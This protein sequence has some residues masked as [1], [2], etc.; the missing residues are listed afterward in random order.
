MPPAARTGTRRRAGA[1]PGRQ[2]AKQ[3]RE[4]PL[5]I[6]ETI[7]DI[8]VTSLAT[9]KFTKN[10]LIHGPSGGGK[11]LL[12]G[13]VTRDYKAVFLSTE[14]E[15]VVSAR[16]AG[17]TAGLMRAPSWEAAVSGVAKAEDTLGPD[18]FLIVDSGTKM[19]VLYMRW[20]L[21]TIHANN[22]QRDLDIPAIQD[23][24][25]YQNGFMRWYDRIIDGPFNSIFITTSMTVEDAE[26]ETRVIPHI[27]GKKGEISDYISA[28]ASVGLYYAVARESVGA[29]SDIIRRALA[30]PYP[31]YWAKDRFTALGRRWDVAEGDYF[32]MADMV[33]AIDKSLEQSGKANGATRPRRDGR[34][35]SARGS[36][37]PA[38]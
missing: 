30:Q 27:M 11:T 26:G 36:R 21:A 22:P 34:T 17:S 32:A 10:I 35:S 15:G 3:V 18:D 33:A 29:S 31:P 38:S 5:A 6:D 12:A 9:A 14:P 37:R 16:N 1:R 4:N 19:Q 20:I 2:T 28:Q 7:V 8:E 24:Q 13:G 25:K 23:H